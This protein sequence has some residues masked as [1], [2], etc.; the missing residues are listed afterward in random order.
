[1][2]TSRKARMVGV[3]T[4]ALSLS[5]G[6]LFLSADAV[7]A[8]PLPGAIFTT[9]ADGAVVNENVRYEAKED[10]NGDGDRNDYFALGVLELVEGGS[11]RPILSRSPI[12]LGMP[13]FQGD[14]DGDGKP[15]PLFVI[16][17]R[18]VHLSVHLAG[19]DAQ[20]RWL[21]SNVQCTL[22]LRNTQEQ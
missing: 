5:T 2:Y 13:D 15:D 8:P 14:V 1:M 9:T 7:A 22:H 10:V 3:A 12:I 11:T 4:F 18:S 19:R 16:D 17:K 6:I 20:G 21:R